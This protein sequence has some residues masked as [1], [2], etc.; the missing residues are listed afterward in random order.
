MTLTAPPTVSPR[1]GSRLAAARRAARPQRVGRVVSAVGLGLTIE[2]LDAAV[3]DVVTLGDDP[4]AD[5]LAEVV[6]TG[7]DGRP[8]HAARPARPA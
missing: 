6:A 5:A 4:G 8:L 1:L 3:G 7:P 2:G